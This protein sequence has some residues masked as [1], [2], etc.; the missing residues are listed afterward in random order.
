MKAL[1]HTVDAQ[2][3]GWLWYWQDEVV[4]ASEESLALYFILD[5]A[6]S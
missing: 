3:D 4:E 5:P 1:D 6:A 2:R